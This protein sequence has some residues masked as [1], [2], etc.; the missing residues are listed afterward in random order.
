[1]NETTLYMFR[2]VNRC[3]K[4]DL[5]EFLGW[6]SELRQGVEGP[7]VLPQGG[8]LEQIFVF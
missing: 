4:H 7:Q 5:G 6:P 1:M 8:T 2:V 3:Q